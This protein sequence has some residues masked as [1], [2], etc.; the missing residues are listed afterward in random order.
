MDAGYGASTELRS[1]IAA[2][3]L[4]YV[5]G[6]LPNTAAWE[7]GEEPLP[8]KQYSGRGRPA[9]VM[10]RDAEHQPIS[11]KDVAL[12]LPASAWR[13]VTWREGSAAPLSSRLARVRARVAHRDYKLSESRPQE[14]LLIEWPKG[15][16]EPT[17]YWLSTLALGARLL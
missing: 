1:S 14:W 2:L 13:K 17:K 9:K 16:K 11:V 10:R 6:I 15:E 4:T 8:P 7:K 5:A 3:G 12:N